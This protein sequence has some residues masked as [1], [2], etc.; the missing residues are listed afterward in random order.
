MKIFKAHSLGNDLLL[1]K[2]NDINLDSQ[3]IAKIGHRKMGI[4][5]DQVLAVDENDNVKIWNN[6]GG[7]IKMCGNGLR[8]LC[9]L[10]NKPYIE[11][12]TA[13]GIV[14]MENLVDGF[15]S[16]ELENQPIISQKDGAYFVQVGVVHKVFF[17]DD[18]PCN[19]EDYKEIDNNVTCVW[20]RD[21]KWF[22]RTMEMVTNETLA[23]GSA[24][25][26]V[27][28]ILKSQGYKDLN[29]NYRY[30]EIKHIVRNDKIVQI[31]PA[32]VVSEIIWY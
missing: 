17:V 5:C 7:V 22:A 11:F 2:T 16:M 10:I 32:E 27:A 12:K 26:S 8:S 9:K 3:F 21:N 18:N 28:A 19:F 29:I 15:V 23:C 31:G 25:L 30:G 13:A 4:G 14:K 6:D 1:I 20:N 24:A